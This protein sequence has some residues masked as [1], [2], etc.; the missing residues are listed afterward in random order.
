MKNDTDGNQTG[1]LYAAWVE[2]QNDLASDRAAD[3]SDEAVAESLYDAIVAYKQAGGTTDLSAVTNAY[4]A[5]LVSAEPNW[6]SVIEAAATTFDVT[7]TDTSVT[8]QVGGNA[9]AAPTAAGLSTAEKT[10]LVDALEGNAVVADDRQALIDNV[11][12]TIAG[13]QTGGQPST[14]TVTFSD[15]DAGESVTV[16]GLTLG[17]NA[18]SG[19]ISAA[20]VA[21]YFANGTVPADADNSGTLTGWTAGTLA[22]ASVPFTST[23]NADVN[24]NV[25]GTFASV[26]TST[27]VG[28]APTTDGASAAYEFAESTEGN[29]YLLALGLQEDRAALNEEIVEQQADVDA[30]QEA[31]TTL[32]SL[33][34]DYDSAVEVRDTAFEALEELGV[35]SLEN[36]EDGASYGV[37][38]T[39]ELFLF[40]QTEDSLSAS[41][42]FE[43]G[44][45]LYVGDSFTRTDLAADADL[46]GERL[47]SSAELEVFF[48]QDGNNAVLSFEQVEFAGNATGGFEGDTITLA[49]VNVEDLQ[50]SN[51][52]VT[53]ASAVEVA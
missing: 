3:G 8:V 2:A 31:L 16:A 32:Q 15:L 19:T 26:D 39:A 5:E 10:A 37:T 35:E 6:G 52:Y 18:T 11:D 46:S 43:A 24:V 30:A 23:T 49:G 13:T 48:Q 50:F 40:S 33:V 20:D 22:T 12:P 7:K 38:D 29:L 44:D 28:A 25:N 41:I 34:A 1:D 53:V 45:Q 51:G 9:L 47:G 36:V 21:A 27:Q 14:D 4:N 42:D 17:A